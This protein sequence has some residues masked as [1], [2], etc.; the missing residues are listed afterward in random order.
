[1]KA[2]ILAA[3]I[4]SRLRPIT[5][6]VPKCMVKVGNETIIER[7]LYS[8]INAGIK[9][10]FVCTGYKNN[11]L[12]N[13]IKNK[14]NFI[15]FIHN[16]N[17]LET[18]N[19]YSMLLTKNE[20]YGENV[21]VMNA[22]VFV[23]PEYIKKLVN[24]KL[25]NCILVEKNRYEEENMKIIYDG[26]KITNISKQIK[27][28]DA[29]GTTIDMYKFS[30]EFTKKWFE[31]MEDIIYNKQEKNMWNEVAIDKMFEYYDVKPLE[32]NNMWFEIDNYED[33]ENARNLFNLNK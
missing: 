22:D 23:D 14:Y 7:Q 30:K 2:F 10:I 19:M 33:L 15:K 31:I 32:I 16:D 27:K 1:M 17:Y 4:G 12:E 6:K 26:N 3:G 24:T 18:N 29:Y 20:A 8:L 11:V 9:D 28:E 5:D 13:F 21:I 25:K